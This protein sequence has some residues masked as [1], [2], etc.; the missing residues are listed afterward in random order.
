V[1][2]NQAMIM[3]SMLPSRP[4]D[5]EAIANF[6][7]SAMREAKAQNRQGVYLNMNA[8]RAAAMNNPA[9][10]GSPAST[11]ATSADRKYDEATN[12][13]KNRMGRVNKCY[14]CG[15]PC[16]RGHGTKTCTVQRSRRVPLATYGA[17]TCAWCY[18]AGRVIYGGH[19]VDTCFSAEESG[20]PRV[21]LVKVAQWREQVRARYARKNASGNG[22]RDSS[23]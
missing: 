16:S 5:H 13:K 18:E 8:D 21:D 1:S 10:Q 9:V 7:R 15:E 4:A 12:D 3:N 6:T 19:G 17:T 2:A 22:P 23:R 14:Q 20:D 11:P